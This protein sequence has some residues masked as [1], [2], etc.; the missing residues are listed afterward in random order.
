MYTINPCICKCTSCAFTNITPHAFSFSFLT[1]F[2]FPCSPHT[3]SFPFS[4][5][6]IPSL[7]TLGPV[8]K[9]LRTQNLTVPFGPVQVLTLGEPEPDRKNHLGR[10]RFGFGDYPEPD[11]RSRFGYV[12]RTQ[13]GGFLPIN[14]T[15]SW[16]SLEN[17]L[18]P[19][20]RYGQTEMLLWLSM[21]D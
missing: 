12:P 18:S 15:W 8:R 20:E 13:H 7:W 6:C 5:V 4:P 1:R 21:D 16:Q 19:E 14:E 17:V 9:L 3:F 11:H 2:R 10:F